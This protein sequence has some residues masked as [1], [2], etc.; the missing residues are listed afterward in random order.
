MTKML[1]KTLIL[2]LFILY[3]LVI[4]QKR[5]DPLPYPKPYYQA[6]QPY[7]NGAGSITNYHNNNNNNIFPQLRYPGPVPNPSSSCYDRLNRPLKCAPEFVNAAYNAPIEATNTCGL[8]GFSQYCFQTGA[9]GTTRKTC[10]ICDAQNVALAHPPE[11]MIDVDQMNRITWW[12]SET[13]MEGVKQ[14]NITIPL[15]KAF[16]ITYVRLL[17]YSPRAESFAIYKRTTENGPWMPF[18]YYSS[19]CLQTYNV[20]DRAYSSHFDETQ[21]MCTK[22]FS[23]ISPLTGG[24]VVFTTLEG[25]P[26]ATHFENNERLQDFV[27]ATDILIVLD[28]MN[29][30]GDEIFGD[31]QVLRSYYYAIS[32]LSIGGICKCNGHSNRCVIPS[33]NNQD[34]HRRLICQ[35]EHNTDGVDCEKCLPFYNDQPWR[36][37][38]TKNAYACQPCNCNGRSNKC[39]FDEV[40]WRRTGH[41][42]HCIDCADDT[43]GPNCERCKENYYTDLETNRC[44]ACNCDPIGS[45]S[46]QCSSTGQCIC[47]SGVE[48]QRCDRC[49]SNYFDF[50]HNGCRPCG[51][52]VEGSQDNVP[53]CDNKG[54]CRCKKNVEGEKC[55]RCKPGFFDLQLTNDLGCVACFCYGHSNQ[56]TSSKG[57][58]IYP[59]ESTF[60]RDSERWIVKDKYG[61]DIS[62]QYNS[63]GQNIG[64]TSS[65]HDNTLYFHAPHKF[66]DDKK[67]SYNRNLTFNLQITGG[68]GNILSTIE[69]IV[70]EGNGIKILSPIFAQGNPLPNSRM[71][72]YR[73]RLNEDMAYGWSPQLN[74]RDFI[75]LLANI[76]AIKIK[77]TYSDMG[78]GFI[79]EVMLETAIASPGSNQ[80]TWVETCSCPDGH[81]GQHCESCTA[82]FKHDPPRGGKAAKCVPCKCNQHGEYCDSESGR[83]CEKCV[84]GYR[85]RPEDSKCEKCDCN[86]NIDPNAI[87]NCN[88]VTGQCLKCIYNTWGNSCE[89]CLPGHYGSALSFPRGDCKA[90]ACYPFGTIAEDNYFD[91]EEAKRQGYLK[92]F[93]STQNF[94]TCN[95]VTGKCRCKANVAGRQCDVCVDGY[96][97][98][99]SNEGCKACDCN[100]I[101]SENHLCDNRSGQCSCRSGVT[102]KHCDQCLPNYFGFGPNGCQKCDCDPI[103]SLE[104][105][106]DLITGQCKCREN[107]EGKQCQ[108][109][110]ENKYNK[111]AGCV[112]CPPCYT[113]V[114][115][116][117]AAHRVKVAGLKTLLDEIEQNPLAVEDANFE[118]QLNEVMNTVKQLLQEAKDAQIDDDSLVAQLEQIKNRIR[119]VQ[120]MTKKIE[121]QMNF[122]NNQINYGTKNITNAQEIVNAAE[123]DLNNARNHL[124]NDG[125]RSLEK[126]RMRAEKY[127][128]QSERMSEIA[129]ESRLLADGHESEAERII[130]KFKDARNISE[131]AYNLA[132]D[133]INTQKANKEELEKLK[134]KLNE[135]KEQYQM[136][137]KLSQDVHKDAEKANQDA[138]NLAADVNNIFV[139]DLN[140]SRYKDEAI[141]IINK[142][143]QAHIDA[144]NMLKTHEELLNSTGNRLN[145]GRLLFE[146]AERKQQALDDLLTRADMAYN[147]TQEAVQSGNNILDDAKNTLKTLKEFDI[148]VQSSKEKANKAMDRVPEI[149][150]EIDDIIRKSD[151]SLKS[152]NSALIEA[153]NAKE[154]AKVAEEKADHVSQASNMALR[155]AKQLTVKA[156]DLL[157]RSAELTRDVDRTSDKMKSYEQQAEQDESL[158]DDALRKANT[159]KTSAMDAIKKVQNATYTVDK[160]LKDL[161][162][163]E[164][165]DEN[166]LS[167]LEQRL[168]DAEREFR[169]ADLDSRVMHLEKLNE[170]QKKSIH[171][172]EDELEKLSADVANIAKIRQSLP[173]KCFRRNRLEP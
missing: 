141:H 74:S 106:C 78:S 5:Y 149:E 2:L 27:T 55:D 134:D 131:T 23:D 165:M 11:Y 37:A 151:Y 52:S 40:L 122:I 46:L 15:G 24:N 21:A 84:D 117:I 8:N 140:A 32:D 130:N 136:T 51:C 172:Y 105:Q 25:R 43:D 81:T 163:M 164:D 115:E 109:C 98:L 94:F 71:Q 111:E 68:K 146:D 1:M 49:A 112:D 96:W 10:E 143:K 82:G 161:N 101:G 59:I 90:C 20:S 145:D 155:T 77:A 38:T 29:T 35:C 17:F 4:G 18:Q 85:M 133:A 39:Y 154:T 138:L 36:R 116:S 6:N 104:Q 42:G 157:V 60:N 79:D 30:F 58:S 19:N 123:I 66:L 152:L 159:A 99:D 53:L 76:T 70:I 162:S 139:P 135:V 168:R 121:N 75:A 92:N 108:R 26:N 12:Q 95:S 86:G 33:N 153:S 142:A 56:C 63:L 148:H 171:N 13:M 61:N 107:V 103:G 83:L 160:I 169:T 170:E 156:D 129:R 45:V 89:K 144:D 73:F 137:I 166:N 44:L 125:R 128:H 80:A 47:K 120:D 14:V 126:A 132:K 64:A 102:G 67:Y 50:S 158:V 150:K 93:F 57:Y 28:N 119:K 97:D 34:G 72:T 100:E 87:G 110:Q 88:S 22:E 69:D 113:L 41:G 9:A 147:M 91:Y 127:G 3:S 31:E 114:Q 54:K 65:F 118:R 124:E 62:I 173:D 7:R 167:D 16:E 48:G